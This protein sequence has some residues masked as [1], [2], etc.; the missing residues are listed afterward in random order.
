MNENGITDNQGRTWLSPYS[1][2]TAD[3]VWLW[4]K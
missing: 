1:Y 3:A 4:N 2:R